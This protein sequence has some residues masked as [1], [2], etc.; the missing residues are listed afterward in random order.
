MSLPH[1]GQSSFGHMSSN[2]HS[3]GRAP[4]FLLTVPF[5]DK[6]YGDDAAYDKTSGNNECYKM[7]ASGPIS[8]ATLL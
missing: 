8:D 1:H 4:L 7:T 5:G 6:N 3:G 2:V